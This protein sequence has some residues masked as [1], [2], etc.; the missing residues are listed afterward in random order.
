MPSIKNAFKNSVFAIVSSVL[1]Y[2]CA[3]KPKVIVQKPKKPKVIYEIV[4]IH[5]V[6]NDKLKLLQ[7]GLA[8]NACRDLRVDQ[9]FAEYISEFQCLQGP[10]G[11]LNSELV[12]LM[13]KYSIDKRLQYKGRI[14]EI[15]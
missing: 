6:D 1:L 8:E 14:Y 11:I 9:N 4:R 7:M 5:N 10:E 12:R 2:A 15:Y 13:T 3:E